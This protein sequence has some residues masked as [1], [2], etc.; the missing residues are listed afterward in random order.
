MFYPEITEDGRY[1][2]IVVQ[3]TDF[4]RNLLFFQDLS[5]Q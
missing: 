5:Q 4:G 2:L 3:T 1:M